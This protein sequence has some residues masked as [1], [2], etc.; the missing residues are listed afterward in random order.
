[1]AF[2]DLPADDQLPAA[3]TRVLEQWRRMTGTPEVAPT[4]RTY[5][6]QPRLLEGRIH[7]AETLIEQRS[8]PEEAQYVAVMLIAHARRCRGCFNGSR[9]QLTRLGFDEVAMDSMCAHPE[10]LPLAPRER[11]FVHFALKVVSG[12]ADLSPKDFAEMAD[13]GFSREDVQE[14]IGLAGLHFMVGER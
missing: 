9:V 10:S 2:F 1:M 4:W 11:M 14:I 13:H 5:A 12:A 6:R 7:A 8:I 3:S